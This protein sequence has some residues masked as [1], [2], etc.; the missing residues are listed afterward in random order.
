MAP[1][2]EFPRPEPYPT[3]CFSGLRHA[4]KQCC[5]IRSFDAMPSKPFWRPSF[6]RESGSH[7][8]REF[9]ARKSRVEKRIRIRDEPSEG[10]RQ[11]VLFRCVRENGW[12]DWTPRNWAATMFGRGC[13]PNGS[14]HRDVSTRA[15]ALNM[16]IYNA[17][18]AGVPVR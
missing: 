5:T 12:L 2:T 16:M 11:T 3:K 14:S 7:K 4:R 15:A 10:A 18:A 13:G 8:T 1:V 9:S 6:S 17:R